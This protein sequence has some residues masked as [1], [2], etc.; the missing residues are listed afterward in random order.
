MEKA[1]ILHLR[2]IDHRYGHG[3]QY[4]VKERIPEHGLLFTSLG[5]IECGRHHHDDEKAIGY[6]L[7]RWNSVLSVDHP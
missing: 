1:S 7:K 6:K 5:T 3:E 2:S 4:S